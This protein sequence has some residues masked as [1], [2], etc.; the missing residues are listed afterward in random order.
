[1]FMTTIMKLNFEYVFGI[2]Q[3]RTEEYV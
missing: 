1:M 3:T 2:L